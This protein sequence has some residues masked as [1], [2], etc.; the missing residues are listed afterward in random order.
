MRRFVLAIALGCALSATALAGEIPSTGA[1]APVPSG[2]AQTTGITAT[3]IL[4]I[5]SLVR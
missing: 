1:P 4:T 5:L 2:T 3:V